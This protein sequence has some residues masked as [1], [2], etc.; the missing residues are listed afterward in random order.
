[1][2]DTGRRFV[3]V[4]FRLMDGFVRLP[5]RPTS[6]VR[7]KGVDYDQEKDPGT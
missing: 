4:G 7:Q 1:M 5:A 6:A 2:K 3:K